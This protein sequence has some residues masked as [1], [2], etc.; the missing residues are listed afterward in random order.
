[1]QVLLTRDEIEEAVKEY[2]NQ[3]LVGRL[4]DDSVFDPE[5]RSVTF[6]ATGQGATVQV[7]WFARVE[8]EDD[9]P[10]F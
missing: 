9:A 3:V 8:E 5:V 2:V 10:E 7:E 4:F 6:H 1:M